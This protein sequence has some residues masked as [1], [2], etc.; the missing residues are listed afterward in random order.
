MHLQKEDQSI[1]VPPRL[2]GIESALGLEGGTGWALG[3][4]YPM[5]AADI[6]DLEVEQK[7][8]VDPGAGPQTL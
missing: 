3:P 7:R 2:L 8:A 1:T 4:S 6:V 5:Y